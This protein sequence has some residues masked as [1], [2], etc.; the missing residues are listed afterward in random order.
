MYEGQW[1]T[2]NKREGKGFQMWED[3][4][5]YIGYWKN[6]LR[7]GKG[8]AIYPDGSFYEGLWETDKKSGV[9]M[10]IRKNSD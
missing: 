5:I 6:D 2:D 1:T 8:L 7:H 3:T 10:M 9:G 4:T